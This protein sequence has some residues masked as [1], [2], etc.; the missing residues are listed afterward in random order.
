MI[1]HDFT[2]LRGDFVRVVMATC[3][4]R[5]RQMHRARCIRRGAVIHQPPPPPSR[6]FFRRA[7]SVGE[8]GV[9]CRADSRL[10]V[11]GVL[12]LP[13]LTNWTLLTS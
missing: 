4:P 2:P 13:R 3:R 12:R 11:A 6:S 10:V 9:D 5:P 7:P 1:S 8:T